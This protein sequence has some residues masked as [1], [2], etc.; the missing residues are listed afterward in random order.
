MPARLLAEWYTAILLIVTGV[1][2][3]TAPVQWTQFFKE[4]L[5]KPWGGLL[6]GLMH[7]LPA[8]AIVIAHNEWN[9]SP[10]LIV[11]LLGWGWTIK[12]SLY[13]IWPWIPG[14]IAPRHLERPD[15]FRIAGL[16]LVVLGLAVLA[17][18]LTQRS[19]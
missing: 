16:F 5:A 8:L 1:S 17:G 7:L 12:G 15:R 19:T 10:G 9:L 11:T 6:L 18:L 4:L 13:L 2:H 3:L 14:R